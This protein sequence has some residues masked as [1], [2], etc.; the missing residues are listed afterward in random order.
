M[1]MANNTVVDGDTHPLYQI[2][3]P[4]ELRARRLLQLYFT[5]Q[6][7][8][9]SD[10]GSGHLGRGR[11]GW[12]VHHHAHLVRVLGDGCHNLAEIA[13]GLWYGHRPAAPHVLDEA[14]YHECL[15]LWT[16]AEG[17][18]YPAAW[19]R[20]S[21]VMRVWRDFWGLVAEVVDRPL[22]AGVPL[23]PEPPESACQSLLNAMLHHGARV[24]RPWWMRLL[25]IPGQL[26]TTPGEAGR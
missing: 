1:M 6:R 25:R 24:R 4:P 21:H 22:R 19:E 26:V 20:D 11:G 2:K 18:P 23:R 5:L 15:W 9:L 7:I 8:C 3:A 10:T 14:L 16:Q 13:A 17:L 12:D